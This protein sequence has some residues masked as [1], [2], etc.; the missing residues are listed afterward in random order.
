M[1]GCALPEVMR[2][3][4]QRELGLS[5][6]MVREGSVV[7]P[8]FRVASGCETFVIFAPIAGTRRGRIRTARLVKAFMMWKLTQW[9]VL[10]SETAAPGGIVSTLVARHHQVSVKR[11]ISR[12]PLQFAEPEWTGAD[13]IDPDVLSLLP[14]QCMRMN[15]R[16]YDQLMSGFEGTQV[17]VAGP[18]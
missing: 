4:L 6:R 16:L 13:S 17:E 15:R 12:N 2:D 9:F 3:A 5:E 14:T 7:V 10:S 1:S 8:R 11:A 18:F